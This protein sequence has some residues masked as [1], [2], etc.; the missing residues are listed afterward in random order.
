MLTARRVVISVIAI[1]VLSLISIAWAVVF[2]RY[3]ETMADSYGVHGQGYRALYEI[4]PELGIPVKRLV[5]PPGSFLKEAG[6]FVYLRPRSGLVEQ[7]PV[8]LHQVRDWVKE[9]GRVVVTPDVN[10]GVEERYEHPWASDHSAVAELGISEVAFDHISFGEPDTKESNSERD[11]AK[12]LQSQWFSS[13]KVQ[14]FRARAEGELDFHVGEE[15][16]LQGPSEDLVVFEKLPENATGSVQ[17]YDQFHK[18]RTVA[19]SL[20]SGSGKAIVLSDARLLEN[21][22]IATAFNS[23]LAMQLIGEPSK[24]VVF[25]EFYHGLTIRGNPFFLIG[26]L[27]YGLLAISVL[28]GTAVWAWRNSVHLGPPLGEHHISRRDVRE[29]VDAMARFL[30]SGRGGNTFMLQEVRD[31]VIRSQFDRLGLPPGSLDLEKLL[32]V[33]ERRFPECARELA[34]A[35]REIDSL[36]SQPSALTNAATVQAMQRISRCH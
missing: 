27:P 12:L 32:A 24:P 36:L 1:A 20:R 11:V 31:A 2:K 6:V 23:V 10:F 25:D 16:S 18:L 17:I 35:C 8:Y 13:N 26:R 34:G 14:T 7:E 33:L 9:G 22:N 3:P 21:R 4:L 19:A 15:F 5:T 28:I 30:K 29:Y